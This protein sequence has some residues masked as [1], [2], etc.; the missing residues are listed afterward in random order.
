MKSLKYMLAILLSVSVFVVPV[1]AIIVIVL[2]I[3][4]LN[5]TAYIIGGVAITYS[6][7]MYKVAERLRYSTREAAEYD[8]FGRSKKKTNI[9]ALSAKER[10]ALDMQ[11]VTDMERILDTTAL[12]KITKPGSTDPEGDLDKLIGLS[13]TKQKVREMAARMKF[14]QEAAKDKKKKGQKQQF[15][16]G[17]RHM[18]FMGSAG[19][20]KTTVCRI[21]TG[22]LYKY[23]YIKENK[24]V[25]VDGNFLKAGTSTATKTELVIRQAYGGVL[26][27]DEAYALIQGDGYGADAIAT[28]IKRMEDARDKFILVIAGYTNEMKQLLASNPGFESRIKEFLYFPDYTTQ[29]MWE[30]FQFMANEH[31]Y[32]TAADAYTAFEARIEKEKQQPAFGNAR[33]VRNVLDETIDKHAVNFMNNMYTPDDRYIIHNADINRTLVNYGQNRL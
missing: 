1:V 16:M 9:M 23:G 32:V 6:V 10:E 17:S 12:K 7:I 26:F 18:C 31:G 27:V 11:K 4:Q 20:G 2:V 30:I 15:S 5:V 25:E 33:T 13:G 14:E 8:E 21:L 19:T 3:K 29:E 24:C 22:F 28:L